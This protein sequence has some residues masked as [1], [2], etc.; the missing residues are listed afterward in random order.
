MLAIVGILLAD[1]ILAWR[2]WLIVGHSQY[3]SMIVPVAG[4]VIEL[5]T[6]S[7]STQLAYYFPLVSLITTAYC[8]SAIIFHV[9]RQNSRLGWQGVRSM[10][11][12]TQAIIESALLYSIVLLVH[13]AAAWTGNPDIAAYTVPLVTVISVRHEMISSITRSN[14]FKGIAPTWIVV[15]FVGHG[16]AAEGDRGHG[17][18]L[19]LSELSSIG[20]GELETGGI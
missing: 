8:S 4:I 2:L 12:I 15:R 11:K 19:M 18:N 13:T 6:L 7:L 20:V 17:E 5:V 16:S 9:F 10:G 14:R 3:Q 1:I